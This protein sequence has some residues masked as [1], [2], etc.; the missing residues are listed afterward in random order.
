MCL[1]FSRESEDLC[2]S[3][4]RKLC[5]DPI[6]IEVLMASRLIVLSK[7]PG[8]RPIGVGEVCRRLIGKAALT[9]IRQDVIEITGCQ[10]LCA[11]G[12][13]YWSILIHGI[14]YFNIAI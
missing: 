14:L 9:V 8:V 1:S 4:A 12:V 6:G 11:R 7:H 10:Q 3:V 13:Q 2:E 5:R